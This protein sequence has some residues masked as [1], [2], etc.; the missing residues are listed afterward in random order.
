LT[1]VFFAA[2]G[3]KFTYDDCYWL[4]E[5]GELT[6]FGIS[7]RACESELLKAIRAG[8]I[9]YLGLDATR[10]GA[11]DRDDWSANVDVS[12]S[13]DIY[14]GVDAKLVPNLTALIR[15]AI[16]LSAGL[17]DV[18]YG[19]GYT[20][21]RSKSPALYASGRHASSLSE[22][23]SMI[24]H[25]DEWQRRVKMPDELWSEELMGQRRHLTGLFRGAYPANILSEAHVRSAAL[26]SRGIG[27]LTEL[28]NSLWLWELSGEEIP[29]AQSILESRGVLVS[30]AS[31]SK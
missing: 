15:R 7:I 5:R 8:E 30:Q 23:L 4:A 22:A 21:P 17:F 6:K 28:D 29:V 27:K 16:G 19:Y 18:R 1:P 3:G 25:R 20:M 11:N 14:I 13:G 24:R 10:P 26:M 9:T 2:S 12:S 31:A